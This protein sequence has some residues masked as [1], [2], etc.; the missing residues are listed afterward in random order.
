MLSGVELAQAVLAAKDRYKLLSLGA[1]TPIKVGDDGFLNVEDEDVRRAYMKIATRIHPD[2][3]PTFANATRAF[4]CLVRAYELC[5]KPD[6]RG[7]ESDDSRDDDDDDED[8][9]DEKDDEDD[10]DSD[11]SGGAVSN[12][13]KAPT[14]KTAAA[15]PSSDAKG[16]ALGAAASKNAAQKAKPK[17]SKA[18]KPA[19][20][21]AKDKKDAQAEEVQTDVQCPRCHADWG[22][23][24]KSEG[25]EALYT[26]FM[27]GHAQVHCLN[28]LFEFGCL[29]AT[30]RCPY[31]TRT[32]EYRPSSVESIQTC[33]NDKQ[34]GIRKACGKRFCVA[35]FAMSKAKA[36][37]EEARRKAADDA[38]K[39][40]EKS[41]E[42][43][44]S[45]AARFEAATGLDDEDGWLE[46]LG[47]FIVSEDCPRCGKQFTSGHKAHLLKCKKGKKGGGGGAKGGGA[48]AKKR[49]RSGDGV[50][51]WMVGKYDDDDDDRLYRE[52]KAAKKQKPEKKP[53]EKKPAEKKKKA[54]PAEKKK[55]AKPAPARK[56]S[57]APSDDSDSDWSES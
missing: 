31:C 40:R 41:A 19:K 47:A 34:P 36:A 39:Q 57:R 53:A 46:E 18:K 32:V 48:P 26:S 8:D 45:R 1:E 6:L 33:P 24:L 13:H 52:P 2:K 4:Q 16:K 14:K 20:A 10:G 3:L 17:A 44:A 5:C 43:R 28:C 11:Y 42:D 30:H 27:K 50:G 7:D 15:A 29:T 12:R 25:R 38:R 51:S 9:E 23:H 55:K 54:Q 37:E 22:S 21:T 49:K 56:K 35:H